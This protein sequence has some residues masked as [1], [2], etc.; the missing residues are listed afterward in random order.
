MALR[1]DV[2]DIIEQREV[3][4]YSALTASDVGALDE[5]ISDDLTTFAHSTGV[6]DTK[7]DYLAGV[8]S[9]AYQHGPISRLSGTTKVIGNVAITIGVI[10]LATMPQGVP[11]GTLRLQQVLVWSKENS[12]WRLF[13]RQ[14]TKL[15]L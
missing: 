4:F 2:V 10:D 8:R 11:A 6:V 9:G 5:I 12:T 7:A 14:A 3:A 13:L 1:T 15:P